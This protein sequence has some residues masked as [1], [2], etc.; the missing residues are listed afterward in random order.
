MPDLIVDFSQHIGPADRRGAGFEEMFPPNFAA[1]TPFIVPL[2]L[3]SIKDP[4]GWPSPISVFGAA[5]VQW[6][7]GNSWLYQT[8]PAG[9]PWDNWATWTAYVEGIIASRIAEGPGPYE[10]VIWQE[11]DNPNAWPGGAPTEASFFELWSWTYNTLRAVRPGEPLIG[12]AITHWDQ[13]YLENFLTYCKTNSQLPDALAWNEL[14]DIAL[15]GSPDYIPYPG[16]HVSTMYTWMTANSITPMRVAI[17]EYGGIDDNYRPGVAAAY[18]ADIEAARNLPAT[19]SGCKGNWGVNNDVTQLSGLVTDPNNPQP[20][21]IWWVYKRYSDITG[22]LSPIVLAT[23]I[24]GV[25]GYDS[26]AQC[27]RVLV[28]RQG[29]SGSKVALLNNLPLSG[30]VVVSV[31]QI[32]DTEMDALAGPV[33]ISLSVVPASAALSVALPACG[34]WDAFVITVSSAVQVS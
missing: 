7:V 4:S 17:T 33:P 34:P 5:T 19:V 22:T 25:A 16:G 23:N 2:R 32:P 31:E 11:P 18:L 20:R 3:N 15:G 26:T 1:M 6:I 28:S 27:A 29:D 30:D 24:N 12:P 21:S 9:N 13:Q 10:W 14:L 8:P